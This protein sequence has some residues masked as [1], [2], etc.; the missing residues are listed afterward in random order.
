MFLLW[1]GLYSLA[2][3][4]EFH[5]LVHPDA[6]DPGHHCAATE[7]QHQSL[8][9]GVAPVVVAPL[10]VATWCVP[11]SGDSQYFSSLDY[12]LSPSRAPPSV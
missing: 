11:P 9:T 1:L 2:V 10:P 4:P 8:F 12:R 5:L 3:F 6:K 7:L